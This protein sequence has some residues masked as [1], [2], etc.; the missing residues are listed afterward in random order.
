MALRDGWLARQADK[1]KAQEPAM[2]A[3]TR[4]IEAGGRGMT[5]E[6]LCARCGESRVS[7]LHDM[8]RTLCCGGNEHHS[9]KEAAPSTDEGEARWERGEESPDIVVWRAVRR[10]VL[11]YVEMPKSLEAAI[12]APLEEERD[13]LA[14]ARDL[15]LIE[16]ANKDR[17]VTNALRRAEAAE[18]EVERLREALRKSAND[19]LWVHRRLEHRVAP[20][21]FDEETRI[22]REAHGALATPPSSTEGTDDEPTF[23]RLSMHR[24]EDWGTKEVEG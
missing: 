5:D 14:A 19:V 23:D 11:P 6:R 16:V 3:A 8:T 4:F 10:E 15:A 17:A 24:S 20:W 7:H 1:I 9:F 12:R 2:R 21:E 22:L 18:A 13:R